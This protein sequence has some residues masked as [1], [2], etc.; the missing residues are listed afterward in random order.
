M[1]TQQKFETFNDG[2][3]VI[4]EIDDD[5]E[6]GDVVEK[7]RF[8][9]RTVGVRRYYEAMTNKIQIDMLIRI[10]YRPYLTTEYMAEI[11]GNVYEITQAQRIP[12]TKPECTDLSLHLTRRRNGKL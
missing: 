3:C 12:D 8:Q 1:S 4:R 2:I 5:G 7:P 9:E 6:P 10:P 11:C